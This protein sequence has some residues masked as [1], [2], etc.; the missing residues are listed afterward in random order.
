MKAIYWSLYPGK[1]R[2]AV[3][4]GQVVFMQQR[5]E[6][7]AASIHKSAAHVLHSQLPKE[8]VT[9]TEV[10]ITSDL[11]TATV[12]ISI[13]SDSRREALFTKAQEV[14]GKIR[15]RV[16]GDVKIRRIPAIVLKLDTRGEH[17]QAI[18]DTLR[19]L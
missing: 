1:P 18:D 6:R 8:Y 5:A 12:W 17:A 16:A 13:F 11:R 14:T 7:L 9:V 4:N 10:E 19:Q 15:T 3:Y 2:S